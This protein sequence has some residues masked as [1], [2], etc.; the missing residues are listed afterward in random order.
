MSEGIDFSDQHARAV[1]L[2]G[3]PYPPKQDPKVVA[4]QEYVNEMFSKDSNGQLNGQ[5]WYVQ[6]AT[7]A[8]NQAI[9]RVIRHKDDYGPQLPPKC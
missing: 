4:K 1:V 2:T 3:L 6:Q 7:R 8:V 5:S 9:G